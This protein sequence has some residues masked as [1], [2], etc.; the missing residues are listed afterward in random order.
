MFRSTYPLPHAPSWHTA[1]SVKERDSLNFTCR[2]VNSVRESL[3]LL[4]MRMRDFGKLRLRSGYSTYSFGS[5]LVRPDD[6]CWWFGHIRVCLEKLL[7]INVGN[8][9]MEHHN[10]LIISKTVRSTANCTGYKMCVPFL[11]THFFLNFFRS[12]KKLRT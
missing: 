10:L 5:L 2:P 8:A 9:L 12:D 7:I 4:A 11:S 6:H 1:Y 3:V